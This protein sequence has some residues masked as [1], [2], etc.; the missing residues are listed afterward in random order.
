MD[1]LS[2]IFKLVL[3]IALAALLLVT[4]TLVKNAPP[5]LEAP[6]PLV[7]LSVYLTT[8]TVET[9]EHSARPELRPRLYAN[10]PR[11]TWEAARIAAE[12]MGWETLRSDP[13]SLTLQFVAT[14]PL[15]RFEDD[16]YVQAQSA[17]HDLSIIYFHGRSRIGRSDLATN[18]R[19]LLDFRDA[20]EEEL[21]R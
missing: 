4:G 3:A 21:A 15:L 2:F 20:L 10:S 7:R 14:T 8:N 6:G 11:E 9:R 13:D 12:R 16:I 1:A 5:L 18:T 19:H 17:D